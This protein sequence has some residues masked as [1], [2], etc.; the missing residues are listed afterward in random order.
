MSLLHEPADFKSILANYINLHSYYYYYYYCYYY[1]YDYHYHYYC[2][3]K[4]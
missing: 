3:Y 4:S 2:H 1:Y